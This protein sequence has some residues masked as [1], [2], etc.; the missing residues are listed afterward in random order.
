MQRTPRITVIVCA[1]VLAGT[2]A[3]SAQ[4]VDL[5]PASEPAAAAPELVLAG[6]YH[7]VDLFDGRVLALA[8]RP[9]RP[10]TAL[11]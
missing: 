10:A 8:R 7:G 11:A 2:T 1:F 9:D 6:D 5:E 4:D 3:A